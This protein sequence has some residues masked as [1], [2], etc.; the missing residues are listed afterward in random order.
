MNGT[1][2]TPEYL[3]T[4]DDYSQLVDFRRR[5]ISGPSLVYITVDD[6]FLLEFWQPRFTSN[7]TVTTRILTPGGIVIPQQFNIVSPGLTVGTTPGTKLMPGVE[8]YLISA[9]VTSTA[10][11]RG[12]CFVRLTVQRGLGSGDS[13]HPMLMCQ[14]YASQFEYVCWPNGRIEWPLEGRG[15]ES[16]LTVSAPLAGQEI[17]TTVPAGVNWIIRSI[18]YTLAT[19][20]VVAARSSHLV[21]DDG[22]N[23][24][25]EG[26]N[27]ATEAASLTYRYSW[28]AGVSNASDGATVLQGGLPFEL[29]LRTGYRMRT[30]TSGLDA[31]DQYSALAVLL[32]EFT[33]AQ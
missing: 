29:R 32:E 27:P 8:G 23:I 11:S 9:T 20:A 3:P 12:Q 21:I 10:T 17:S 1:L 25:F 4:Q 15:A 6:V 33:A 24:I 26:A 7:L 22:A 18:S 28:A 19:S 2:E 16:V 5:F 13:A 14:G 31:A 30:V